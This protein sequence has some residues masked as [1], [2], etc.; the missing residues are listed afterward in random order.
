M[1]RPK[2]Y[3]T[4]CTHLD[5]NKLQED[6]VAA[7][8]DVTAIIK[9]DDNIHVYSV[10]DLIQDQKD[11]IDLIVTNFV[12]TDPATKVPLIYSIAKAEATGK[13]FHNIDYKK[14]LKSPLIPKRT[15]VQGEVREVTWFEKMDVD[16]QTPI[17]P[18][19]K[20]SI[21]YTRDVS[22]SLPLFRVTTREWYNVD[23]TLNTEQKITP[24]YYFVNPSDQ[25]DEGYRRRGLLV[26]SIQLP[27]M[28]MM[29]QVM[30][31]S[32][33]SVG[34]ILLKGRQ[35]LDDYEEVFNRFIENSSTMTDAADPN[36]GKKTV[37]I[38]L[39]AEARPEV[40]EWMD[41]APA[42]LGGGITIRQYLISE[43]DI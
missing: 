13:H 3:I 17:N 35:F 1:S 21:T 39:E 2:I 15:V 37:I 9:V 24:K 23:G 4:S 6:I 19:I 32:G 26:K 33:Y 36:F 16:G 10:A 30:E 29:V 14:E 31:P 8:S 20:V 5:I 42:I 18:V 7:E 40:L 25:I 11:A 22:T 43:F 12:D 28:Q 34:I 38:K 27:V 41:K